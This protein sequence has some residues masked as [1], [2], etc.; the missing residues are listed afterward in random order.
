M[1]MREIDAKSGVKQVL[2]IARVE[3]AYHQLRALI[4]D[5]GIA[6]RTPSVDSYLIRDLDTPAFREVFNIRPYSDAKITDVYTNDAPSL[7]K[8]SG[9]Q[10]GY[11]RYVIVEL[12]V[13]E[14]YVYED[15]MLK[16]PHN[17][18][19][20]TW[21]QAGDGCEWRR[22]DFTNLKLYQLRPVVSWDGEQTVLA[23]EMP[24]LL[25]NNLVT[26]E[27]QQFEET[28]WKL[29]SGREM[30]VAC[31]I[32][33][34]YSQKP[35]KKYPLVVSLS[36]GGGCLNNEQSHPST[37][38]NL[39]RDRG[40]CAWLTAEEEAFILTPQLYH[41]TCMLGLTEKDDY[42][43][44]CAKDVMEAV[45][46]FIESHRVDEERIYC[47][48]SSLG[49]M[50]WSTVLHQPAY[51]KVFT[52]YIQCNG[53][54]N[55]AHSMFLPEYD[56]KRA[57]DV[58]GLHGLK[59]YEN[60]CL[61]LEGDDFFESETFQKYAAALKNVV[62]YRIAVDVW[63]CL[64]DEVAPTNRGITTYLCLRELYRRKGLSEEAIDELVSLHLLPVEMMHRMGIFSYHQASKAA[65]ADKQMLSRT[66]SLTKHK[67]QRME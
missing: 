37:G 41:K 49:T 38:G 54:F 15:G 14:G 34:S 17:A 1:K 51:A 21:R 23:G 3:N 57:E 65:A 11:G 55:G 64:N 56:Q 61:W 12:A 33:E 59:D 18:G 32:P 2:G 5:Y 13:I 43:E 28:F 31:H 50:V 27:C 60:P 52:A 36:G 44:C 67:L 19:V 7:A 16:P 48:G 29:S 66:L 40:A 35:G 53:H 42:L 9:C 25:Y 22:Q 62:D 8:D 4:L 58:L 46:H 20:C 6:V 39:T 10:T 45:N 24:S 30:Y 47:I 26:E 63:H